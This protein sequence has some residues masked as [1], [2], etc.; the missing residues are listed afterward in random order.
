[1]TEH[2]AKECNIMGCDSEAS[3]WI[4]TSEGFVETLLLTAKAPDAFY[5][6]TGHASAI[7]NEDYEYVHLRIDT[8]EFGTYQIAEYA[9]SE[10]CETCN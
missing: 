8:G 1:M 7:A 4:D 3:K 5:L 10:D 2:I 9:C 6:C